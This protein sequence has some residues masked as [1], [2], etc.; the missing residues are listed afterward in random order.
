[1]QFCLVY[2]RNVLEHYDFGKDSSP[3]SVPM[4]LDPITGLNLND[5]PK[6]DNPPVVETVLSVQFKPLPGMRV[7]HFGQFHELLK[8]KGF[9]TVEQYP[10]LD[11]QIEQKHSIGR[12]IPFP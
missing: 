10:P 6:F 9:E 8:P 3:V 5:T 12:F 1:M 7:S 11:H 2:A 4:A